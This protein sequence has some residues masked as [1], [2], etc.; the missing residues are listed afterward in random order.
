MR[1]GFNFDDRHDKTEGRIGQFCDK[2]FTISRIAVNARFGDYLRTVGLC[3]K[4][5]KDIHAR[6]PIS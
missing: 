3:V 5:N 4:S 2:H 6:R 1:R